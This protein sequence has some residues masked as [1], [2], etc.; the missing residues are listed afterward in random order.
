MP[1]L[2]RSKVTLRIFGKDLNPDEI[3]RR[4]SAT[5]TRARFKGPAQRVAGSADSVHVPPS[6]SWHLEAPECRPEDVNGQVDALLAKLTTDLTVWAS[7]TTD[8]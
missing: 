8:C 6:G 5:P 2:A 1:A 7:I 3:S 4:L